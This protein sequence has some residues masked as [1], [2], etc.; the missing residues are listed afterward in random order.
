MN[1]SRL[2]D[3]GGLSN[4]DFRR[5]LET[6]AVVHVDGKVKNITRVPVK[7]DVARRQSTM[8]T[9]EEDSTYRDRA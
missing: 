8:E 9:E 6:P 2:Q 7:E 4:E 3:E 5:L 1:P